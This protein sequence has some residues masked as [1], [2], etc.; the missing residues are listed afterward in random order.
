MEHGTDPE[1]CTKVGHDLSLSDFGILAKK[2]ILSRYSILSTI[3]FDEICVHSS[4]N[5]DSCFV[6]SSVAKASR[7]HNFSKPVLTSGNIDSTPAS[8]LFSTWK[9][10]GCRP[11][12]VDVTNGKTC[13]QITGFYRWAKRSR[14]SRSL[15]L[16]LHLFPDAWRTVI[17]CV[18][19][20]E[21]TGYWKMT[22]CSNSP[23][24]FWACSAH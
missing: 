8:L 17:F 5:C 10:V 18:K 24:Y 13:T 3:D 21:E 6:I 23:R 1:C 12:P 11:P 16:C 14:G 20:E 2:Q 15:R 7:H 19:Q 22:S 9:H 4:T